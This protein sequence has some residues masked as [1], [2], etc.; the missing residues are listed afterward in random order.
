LELYNRTDSTI[1]IKNWFLGDS[2]KQEL[3]ADQDFFIETQKYI[4]ITEDLDEFL[5]SFP[6]AECSIIEQRGWS[7]LNNTGDKI[8]LKDSLGFFVD[9]VSYNKSW[10]NGVSWERVNPDERSDEEDNWWRCVE[11]EGATPCEKNS[12]SIKSSEDVNLT[13]SPDPF[14]PDGDGFEDTAFFEYSIPLRSEITIKIYDVKGRLVKTLI[15]DYP[16]AS[17]RCFWNGKAD[18]ERIVKAGIYVVLVEAKGESK[19]SFKTTVVVAKR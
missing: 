5:F 13:I 14:S 11:E 9:E 15:E 2:L 7:T 17:G 18:K 8:I 6:Q 1:S 12:I 16:F 4:I 19:S 10:D 3:I